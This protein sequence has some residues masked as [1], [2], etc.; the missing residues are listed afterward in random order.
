MS[1]YPRSALD[2]DFGEL[3]PQAEVIVHARSKENDL[4]TLRKNNG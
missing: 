1:E 2:N 4:Y 3:W